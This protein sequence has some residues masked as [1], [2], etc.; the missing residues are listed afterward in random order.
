MLY[1]SKNTKAK[2]NLYAPF[3]KQRKDIDRSSALYSIKASFELVNADVADIRFFSELAVDPKHCLLAVDLFTSKTYIY[4]MK[5]RNSLARKLDLF[6]QDIQTKREQISK[7]E[8]MRLQTDLEFRQNK[9][10]KL[11]QK[12]NIEMFST[13]VRVGK[14]YAAK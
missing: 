10:K 8:K 1:E 12:Y 6:Y 5:S 9:I 7:N 3:V 13:R 2:I 11:N 4:P 14:A